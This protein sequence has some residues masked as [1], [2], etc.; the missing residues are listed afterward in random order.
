[1]LQDLGYAL[2]TLRKTPAFTAIAAVS[3]A[4]GIGANSAVFSLADGLIMRPLPVPHAN[5]LMAVQSRL[6]GES[7][8]GLLN[9][10]DVSYPDF[11]DLRKA[12]RSFDLLSASEYSPFGFT[13]DPH[14]LPR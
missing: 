4:L 1:M 12:S 2:R 3:L 10:S 14:A 9:Y 6:R 8:G 11:T 5:Q 7:I 13:V